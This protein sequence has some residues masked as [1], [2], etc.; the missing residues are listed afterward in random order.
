MS[1]RRNRSAA[2]AAAIWLGVATAFAQAQRQEPSPPELAGVDVEE[3]LDAALPLGQEFLDETGRAA[4]LADYFDGERPVIL[5]LNYYECPML[6]TLVL[7]GLADALREMDW[8]PGRQFEIV[9]VSID[10]NETPSLAREKKA[11]YLK[12]YGRD[13]AASGW[14]FLTGSE[15][16]IRALAD[17]TGFRYSYVERQ[18][19][20]AHAAV[21]FVVTP[22]G[23]LSRYLYGVKFDPRT[24]RLSLVEASEGA[25]GSTLDRLILYCYH[26][27]SEAGT[28]APKALRIM[29][30]GGLATVLVLGGLLLALW[31]REAR[32]RETA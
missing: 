28:Y 8:V 15:A 26:Y 4:R 16:S 7:N 9:T 17:A 13:E 22:D 25:I 18:D 5:T 30:L 29:Q 6:C 12:A 3:R 24:L 23:R 2:I 27:D 11:T 1:G 21:I 32:R 31:R 14:H 20:W 19:E 10:P